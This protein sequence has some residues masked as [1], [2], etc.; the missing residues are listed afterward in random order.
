MKSNVILK[1]ALQ[2]GKLPRTKK[3]GYKKQSIYTQPTTSEKPTWH[4]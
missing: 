4:L 2:V 1:P 3:H